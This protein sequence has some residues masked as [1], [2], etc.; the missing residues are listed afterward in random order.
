MKV[1]KINKTTISA[2]LPPG[3]L[4]YKA[5]VSLLWTS[6]SKSNFTAEVVQSAVQ[7]GQVGQILLF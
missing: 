4:R 6:T 2:L 1:E 5:Q 3:T 7:S